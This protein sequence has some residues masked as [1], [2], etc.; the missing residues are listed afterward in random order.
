M[1]G[2]TDYNFKSEEYCW[3][4][5]DSPQGK[6][7]LYGQFDRELPQEHPA[8]KKVREKMPPGTKAVVARI[9][10]TRVMDRHPVE[11][12]EYGKEPYRNYSVMP[13][14]ACTNHLVQEIEKLRNVIQNS[15]VGISA[16]EGILIKAA[17]KK[18]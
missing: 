1:V 14:N 6:E 2:I 9:I 8:Y 18:E 17:S 10:D 3:I 12:L 7:Y 16:L 13:A 11:A 4:V 5:L 15:Y